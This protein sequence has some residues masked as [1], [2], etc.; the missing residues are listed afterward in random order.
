M[1]DAQADAESRRALRR[2]TEESQAMMRETNNIQVTE[3]YD[4]K[5]ASQPQRSQQMNIQEGGSLSQKSGSAR[6]TI[7]LSQLQA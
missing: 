7:S 2:P 5:P 1:D 6:A 3:H 4:Y